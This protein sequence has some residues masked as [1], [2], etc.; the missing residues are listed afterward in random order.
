M[1]ED[2]LLEEYNFEG[3]SALFGL[4]NSPTNYHT[5]GTPEGTSSPVASPKK[6]SFVGQRKKLFE[7]FIKSDSE[8][9]DSKAGLMVKTR[10][11]VKREKAKKAK[12]ALP[13]HTKQVE[14]LD[15]EVEDAA[16]AF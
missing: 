2:Q 5:L 8:D 15:K 14:F 1:G 10:A 3:F 12:M 11:K 9:V 13:L 6:P 16:K 7:G 4:I